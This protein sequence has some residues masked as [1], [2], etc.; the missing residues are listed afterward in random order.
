M[1]IVNLYKPYFKIND[2]AKETDLKLIH[3]Y[4]SSI[5]SFDDYIDEI[6]F[7]I[8][9]LT[10]NHFVTSMFKDKNGKIV[11]ISI[12]DN[13]IF[14]N[15]DNIKRLTNIYKDAYEILIISLYIGE[16]KKLK[17]L[18]NENKPTMN[19]ISA[20]SFF[21]NP[22]RHI[23]SP[24]SVKVINYEE[25]ENFW[26]IDKKKLPEINFSDPIVAYLRFKPGDVLQIDDISPVNGK[27]IT[28]RLVI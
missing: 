13:K 10:K 20:Q 17:Q 1:N 19:Y 22:V 25:L 21:V 2:Y 18:L 24:I 16:I 15:T 26:Y 27:F 23:F 6:K 3:G 28:Y 14:S 7:K 8:E 11:Y 9:I 4:I 5:E 12:C